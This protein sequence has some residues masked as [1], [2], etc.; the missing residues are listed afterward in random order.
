MPALLGRILGPSKV[1]T[2]CPRASFPEGVDTMRREYLYDRAEVPGAAGSVWLADRERPARPK[3][4]G[5][6]GADVVVVGGG[7]CGCLTAMTLADAGAKVALVEARRVASDVTGHTTAK[8]T[9]QH[10]LMARLAPHAQEAWLRANLAAVDHLETWSRRAGDGASFVRADS[11]AYVASR[12]EADDVDREAALY[13][14][15]GLDG[16]R[17]AESALPAGA[18][19]AVRLGGQGLLDPVGLVDGLLDSAPANLAVFED[20]LVRD[21][22]ERH[23]LVVAS[24]D[25]GEVRAESAI[26][27]SHVPFFD[28]LLYLTRLFQHR[29]YALEVECRET[30]PPEMWYGVDSTSVA[31]RPLSSERPRRVVISGFGHKAGQGG[32]ERVFYRMLESRARE[33]LGELEVIRHW[34]TQDAHTPDELPYIGK[35]HGRDRCFM[36]SGFQG[37]G[38]TTSAVAADVLS[39][40]VGGGEHPLL[41]IVAPSRIG[42]SG[43]TKLAIE[44]A[45]FIA[46]AFK[47]ETA[48][49]G[50]VSEVRPGEGRTMRTDMGHVAVARDADGTAHVLDAHCTHMRCGVEF[51]E[52]EGTWDCPCHGSRFLGNGEW[53]HGPTR[54]GLETAQ[55]DG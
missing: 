10:G 48:T 31:W 52:A 54:R 30:P 39:V 16:E 5:V 43:I 15:L 22:D 27:A 51:N 42:A 20:S 6:V 8:A 35:M 19:A 53:L 40:I 7:L 34:S 41:D 12:E 49:S 26:I 14:R 38:M 25:F 3:L 2:P 23:D 37:W 4:T 9:A 50:Q 17:L 36:A 45:D 47:Q 24:T 32:D 18:A 21:V 44:N 55:T 33:Q 1:S 11:H 28:T 29:T 13:A 46:Q